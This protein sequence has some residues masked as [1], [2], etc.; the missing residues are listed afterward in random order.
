M[1]SSQDKF[2]RVM[3]HRISVVITDTNLDYGDAKVQ[4]D[5]LDLIRKFQVNLVKLCQFGVIARLFWRN[6]NDQ[7]KYHNTIQFLLCALHVIIEV[8]KLA[9]NLKIF[10]KLWIFIY[11]FFFQLIILIQSDHTKEYMFLNKSHFNFFNLKQGL[12]IYS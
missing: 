10:V 2:F 12:V 7:N 3:N 11:F 1:D 9:S 8:Q 4:E 6:K 5:I